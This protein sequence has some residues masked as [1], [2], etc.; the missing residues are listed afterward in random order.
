[1]RNNKNLIHWGI[2]SAAAN[3]GRGN[4]NA[5]TI[6]T[7]YFGVTTALS[8]F[9]NRTQVF[10]NEMKNKIHLLLRQEK[11]FV[12]CIDNNQKG[13]N[14]KYQIFGSSN[15]FVK[16]TGSVIKKF[17]DIN[18][19]PL[20]AIEGN[21]DITYTKQAIPSP[22][23]FP[24][25]EHISTVVDSG[26]TSDVQ[27]LMTIMDY[28]SLDRTKYLTHSPTYTNSD[29]ERVDYSGH[30]VDNYMDICHMVVIL[31]QMRR[32]CS[33]TFTQYNDKTK[34]VNF[35]PDTWRN[36]PTKDILKK[37][38]LSKSGLLSSQLIQFQSRIVQ[39]WNPSSLNVSEVIV[40]PV[41]L[42]DE[43]TTDGY[44][45]SIIELLELVGILEKQNEGNA[46][47]LKWELMNDWEEKKCTY[48]SMG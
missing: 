19:M 12:C 1:M 6:S 11:K 18:A 45:K 25:F 27:L 9:M 32:S 22:F 37:L 36:K 44:G 46:S 3:Y 2:V 48:V 31:N 28:T 4:G 16:V 35:V 23:L 34:F 39:L 13:H 40:P 8:T 20:S 26:S 30:R 47:K 42:H 15:R 5:N 33:G 21:T 29:I 10:R 14:K 38:T 17:I 24:H 41:S 7:T 43:I